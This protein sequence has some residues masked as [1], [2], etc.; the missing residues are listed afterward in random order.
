MER[1]LWL[2]WV[3]GTVIGLGVGAGLAEVVSSAVAEEGG[4]DNLLF[5]PRWQIA[6][7]LSFGAPG[8][9]A[10]YLVL[11]AFVP[12]AAQWIART[13][14]GLAIGAA[15]GV[16][17]GFIPA[18]WTLFLATG[19]GDADT[20]CAEGLFFLTLPVAGGAA[21]AVAGGIMGVLL[22]LDKREW[23]QEWTCPLAKAWA[24]IGVT[25]WTLAPLLLRQPLSKAGLLDTD[26]TLAT[27]ALSGI[28]GLA[29]GAVGGV[30]SAG[31]FI[32]TVRAGGGPTP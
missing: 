16:F 26:A 14:T 25:F 30:L 15:V 13:T 19:C 31:H 3:S 10:Q 7:G 17:A 6:V 21:G 12:G 9:L 11:R 32:R 18:I 22:R 29:A 4:L 28:A 2:L 23:L 20:L 27:V 8:L 1:R 5:S 24:G